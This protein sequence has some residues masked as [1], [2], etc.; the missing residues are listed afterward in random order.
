M[1]DVLLPEQF[2]RPVSICKKTVLAYWMILGMDFIIDLTVLAM[3]QVN[4]SGCNQAR[5]AGV[6]EVPE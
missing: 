1:S 3:F 4:S 2:S 6:L 5:V